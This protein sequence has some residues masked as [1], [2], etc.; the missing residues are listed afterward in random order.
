VKRGFDR[1][2]RRKVAAGVPPAVE[3]GV[4]PGGMNVRIANAL[5]NLSEDPGGKMPPSTAGGTPAA[6]LQWRHA[7]ILALLPLIVLL[8]GCDNGPSAST[9]DA[10]KTNVLISQAAPA[11]NQSAVATN[12]AATAPT[13]VYTYEVVNTFPHDHGAFTQGLLYLDGALYESTG[14][15]GRSSLRKVD[16]GTG[17]VLKQLDVPR[18]YFAEGLAALNGKLYQLTWQNEKGFVY[19]LESFN[20]ERTFTYSAEGWGLTTDGQSLIMS[21]GTAQIRF[22]DPASF[23]VKRTITAMDHDRSIDRLNEL[24]Y[25]KGEIFANVWTTDFIVRIDPATGKVLGVID[26]SGLLAPQDRANTDVLNGIAYD[27]VDD[28]LFV[29][30][31]LWPKLFEV[32]LKPKP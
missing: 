7:L 23:Q 15:N 9:A 16:L 29:T 19:D 28:R 6:T 22:L 4:S 2:R 32:R 27:A 20:Q 31:K 14:L 1:G 18:E 26:F 12:S 3:P 30:G 13:P 17:T 10:G 11:L 24:E 21:D 5:E 25:V 8:A